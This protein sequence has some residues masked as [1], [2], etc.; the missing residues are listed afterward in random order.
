MASGRSG[1][2][3]YVLGP[4]QEL[5]L[6]VDWGQKVELQLMKG[7]AEIFGTEMPLHHT[8][9]LGVCKIAI[10][11]WHG[12]TVE[13]IGSH[14]A[15][16]EEDTPMVLYANTH[17]ILEARRV[18]SDNLGEPAPRVVI[19]GPTDTGKSS[20]CKI[21]LG[22]ASRLGRKPLYVDLDIG[23]GNITVP[24]MISAIHADRPYSMDEGFSKQV[25]LVYFY[26]HAD[27]ATNE[28]CYKRQVG[29]LFKELDLAV[30][31]DTEGK[32]GTTLRKES[33]LT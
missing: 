33:P 28:E 24:G 21:L 27:L 10:F 7:M 29:T 22:Y 4:R 16:T 26:G 2:T 14:N 17:G 12:A 3:S 1:A 15:Y 30:K 32:L 13:L 11:T 20:L 23:Q 31:D 25:P 19:A 18:E 9:H 8:F 5:R 6:E